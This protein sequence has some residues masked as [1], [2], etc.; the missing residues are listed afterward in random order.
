MHRKV[1]MGMIGGGKGAF[2]GNI[3]RMAARM[4]GRIEMVCGAASSDR[5][6]SRESGKA[7]YLPPDRVYETYSEMIEKESNRPEGARMDFVS[8]VTPNH[9]H[10]EPARQALRHGFH[11][12][13]D[14][15]M[16][17]DLDEARQLK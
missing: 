13:M 11:V 2:I 7:L 9:V 6:T 4:D 15:P 16:T 5:E 14:K 12:V 17:F 1:R 3:H 8:I 10:F